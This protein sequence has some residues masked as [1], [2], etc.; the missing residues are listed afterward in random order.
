MDVCTSHSIVCILQVHRMYNIILYIGCKYIS[1]TSKFYKYCNQ[2]KID[3][4][5]FPFLSKTNKVIVMHATCTASI[6]IPY[7]S[8]FS[9]YNVLY[10]RTCQYNLNTSRYH[11]TYC[12]RTQ[13]M[14]SLHMAVRVVSNNYTV[15][16]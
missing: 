9:I 11:F 15:F 10:V 7:H 8:Y 13:I 16:V 5:P 4:T 14:A 2:S 6:T 3:V 1:N 12:V